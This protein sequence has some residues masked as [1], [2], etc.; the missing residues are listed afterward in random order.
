[1]FATCLTLVVVP[2]NYLVAYNIKYGT[3]RI[4][5]TAWENWLEYWNKP[6]YP[7]NRG[8]S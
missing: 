2:V 6:D 5:K 8:Q 4:A 3:K 7:D 1:L